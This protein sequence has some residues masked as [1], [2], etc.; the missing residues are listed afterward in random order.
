MLLS[1]FSLFTCADLAIYRAVLRRHWSSRNCKN[2]YLRAVFVVVCFFRLFIPLVTV[3][4]IAYIA[5]FN[6]VPLHLLSHPNMLVCFVRKSST[7]QC[8]LPV[9][10][11]APFTFLDGVRQERLPV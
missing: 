8:L 1:P 4:R 11:L 9:D 2:T 5:V 3:P 6:G 10:L 7:K